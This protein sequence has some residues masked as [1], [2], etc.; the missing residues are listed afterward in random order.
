MLTSIWC[1]Q[2]AAPR[3]RSPPFPPLLRHCLRIVTGCHRPTPSN[4]LP[5]RASIQPA[6]PSHNSALHAA[7]LWLKSAHQLH[8]LLNEFAWSAKAA[9][10][11]G[12]HQGCQI[13]HFWNALAMKK[14]IWPFHKNW[15]SFSFSLWNEIL[16]KYL[17]LLYFWTDFMSLLQW[18]HCTS[19]LYCF[20]GRYEALCS[21]HVSLALSRFCTRVS[22][23]PVISQCLLSSVPSF[24]LV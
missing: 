15:P 19:A 11:V 7:L 22:V 16:I 5:V 18:H 3:G 9:A 20:E 10:K 13:G 14:R 24:S 23:G 2:N 21:T 17:V 12:T 4:N 6:Q 8:S 1:P